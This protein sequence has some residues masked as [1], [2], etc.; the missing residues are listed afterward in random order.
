MKLSEQINADNAWIADKFKIAYSEVSL[1]TPSVLDAADFSKLRTH[2]R[3]IYAKYIRTYRENL[4]NNPAALATYLKDLNELKARIETTLQQARDEL[5]LKEKVDVT[6]PD[7]IAQD[8]K[9]TEA[10]LPRTVDLSKTI[11]LDAVVAL[12]DLPEPVRFKKVKSTLLESLH[13]ITALSKSEDFRKGLAVESVYMTLKPDVSDL[14]SLKKA[15]IGA[16]DKITQ[17]TSLTATE[18]T[19]YLATVDQQVQKI[20]LN[21]STMSPNRA[22]AMRLFK[23]EKTPTATPPS[24][25]PKPKK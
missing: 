8:I 18:K 3:S 12:E 21:L 11:N 23:A 10:K 6:A 16:K 5:K 17:A 22:D 7:V 4:G 2:Y 15:L 14:N 20:N 25:A 13:N 19:S 1:H 9:R 24:N